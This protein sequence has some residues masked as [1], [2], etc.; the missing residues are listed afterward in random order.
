MLTAV[1][2]TVSLSL[3]SLGPRRTQESGA[4]VNGPQARSHLEMLTS[5]L[6]PPVS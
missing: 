5:V 4:H 1:D 3:E 2:K 6:P